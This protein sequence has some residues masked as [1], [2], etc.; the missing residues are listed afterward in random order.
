MADRF[1]LIAAAGE[2]A[3][4]Y[5]LTGWQPEEAERAIQQCFAA[6]L[7][8]R[9]T[10]GAAEPHAI[11][12]QVRSFLET[13]GESRFTAWL[14]DDHTPRTIN[15]AGYRRR[16]ETGPEYYVEREAFRRELSAG[17]DPAQVAR[18]L[19]EVGALTVGSD[20]RPDSKARLPDGR[21]TRVFR[22]GPALW[23]C[24]A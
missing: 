10:K 4:A 17:F 1:A 23:E 11:L 2:L 6:W 18:V 14:T 24:E 16:T 13:H 22:I 9:G 5:G 15:R 20:G 21:N 8:G 12:S 19:V 7:A 3:T